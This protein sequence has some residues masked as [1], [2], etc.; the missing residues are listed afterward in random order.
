MKLK[1]RVYLV[2]TIIKNFYPL[3][4]IVFLVI[5]IITG[6]VMIYR[7]E[8]T[9]IAIKKS[10]PNDESNSIRYP[11]YLEYPDGST[12]YLYR[13]EYYG[14]I[15]DSCEYLISHENFSHKGNCRFCEQRKL[16]SKGK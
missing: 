11:A 1:E 4:G 12:S 14:I 8:E 16:Q 10:N 13:S 3:I 2:K 9:R 6:G 7:N 15:I 5:S